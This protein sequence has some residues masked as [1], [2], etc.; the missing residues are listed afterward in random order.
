MICY[1]N[2]ALDQF[3]TSIIQKLSLVPGQV[4]RVGGRS[5][6]PEMQPFL[7]QKLRQHGHETRTKIDNLAQRYEILGSIKRQS[8][9]YS[10]NYA[11]CCEK[12]L[13]IDQLCRI[14]D[15]AQI[16]S[17]IEPVLSKLDIYNTHWDSNAGGLY[18]CSREA[19]TSDSSTSDDE[20]SEESDADNENDTPLSAYEKNQRMKNRVFCNQ[21]N[22][23]SAEDQIVV[24]Q[25]FIKWLDATQLE[26]IVRDIQE[27]AEG[28]YPT[29]DYLSL[30]RI[31]L[32]TVLDDGEGKFIKKQNKKKDKALN[33]LKG[34]TT[35]FYHLNG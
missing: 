30:E 18:C 21:L 31:F 32:N 5:A 12:I 20:E 4:V 6:H 2:H 15:K 10:K 17:L 8:E 27:E 7:I 3:L 1:T 28:R 25:L 14:M 11:M 9:E 33:V 34:R 22:K 29:K 19:A 16:L 26:T 23:L 35:C 24:N 13:G